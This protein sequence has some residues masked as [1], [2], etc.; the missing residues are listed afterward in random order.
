MPRAVRPRRHRTAGSEK[1]SGAR[2]E[3]REGGHREERGRALGREREG[4]GKRA[5]GWADGRS[6]TTRGRNTFLF[7]DSEL[8]FSLI[9]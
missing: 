6:A 3:A 1:V 7:L 2:S 5:R 4:T 9:K 8:Y